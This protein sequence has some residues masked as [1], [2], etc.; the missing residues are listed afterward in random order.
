[1][2]MMANDFIL[3]QDGRYRLQ[4][5]GD[6]N[7]VLSDTF[8]NP[9]TVLWAS[10][11]N[12]NN[13]GFVKLDNNGYLTIVNGSGNALWTKPPSGGGTCAVVQGD[14]NFVIYSSSDPSTPCSG[15][16]P[17]DARTDPGWVGPR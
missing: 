4:Y 1:D 10:G 11:T 5:Q 2:Y 8:T 14:N 6:G 15:S 3:S 12:D 7:L 16:A 9:W 13:P 17:W